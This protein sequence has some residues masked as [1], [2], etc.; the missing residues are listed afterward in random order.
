[1]TEDR[2]SERRQLRVELR[3]RRRALAAA[4]R[5]SAAERLADRLLALPFAPRSGPVAGYWASDGEIALHAWQLRLPAGCS[6]CLPV[7]GHGHR[8]HFAPWRPGAALVNNRFGIPEPDVDRT[9]LLD[10]E[11]MTL[12]VVPLVGFDLAGQRLGMGGGWYDRNFA[13]RRRSPAPPWM[14]GAAFDLQQVGQLDAAEWDVP[15]DAVCTETSSHDFRHIAE[16]PA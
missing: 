11:A 10:P 5:M 13:F 12:V 15:L 1:M 9:Q 14:V 7:L 16:S 4:T 8:L 6:Y 3:H 2:A